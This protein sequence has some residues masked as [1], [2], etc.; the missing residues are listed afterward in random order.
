MPK[1]LKRRQRA[2][3]GQGTAPKETY[4]GS[5]VWYYRLPNPDKSPGAPRQKRYTYKGE[6]TGAPLAKAKRLYGQ[7]ETAWE[8]D[9]LAASP[10]TRT[11]G[12]VLTSWLTAGNWEPET[13]RHYERHAEQSIRPALGAY[14]L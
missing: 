12:E 1:A 7:A 9:R 6:E 4:P 13:R 3:R 8:A 5:G 2:E 14:R 10:G 11:V